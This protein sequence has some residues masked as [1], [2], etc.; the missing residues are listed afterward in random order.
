MTVFGIDGAVIVLDLERQPVGQRHL[1]SAV[2]RLFGLMHRFGSAE[3]HA[4]QNNFLGA[5]FAD[6][7][8][9]VLGASGAGNDA[10]VVSVCAKRAVSVA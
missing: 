8:G 6:R 2:Y 4:A 10:S 9:E 3:R 7:A 5:P 1:T